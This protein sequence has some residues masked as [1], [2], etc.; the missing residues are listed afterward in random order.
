[1]SE[2]LVI[3]ATGKTGSRVVQRLEA[4]GARVRPVNR[5]SDP[6]FEWEA[7]ETWGQALKSVASAYVVYSPDLALPSARPVIA[8]FVKSAEKAGLK[9][10]VLLSQRNEIRAEACEDLIKKSSIEWTILKPSWFMQNFS[11]G[12]L[13][14]GVLT[15]T[16][17]APDSGAT[18]PWVDLDDVADVAVAALMDD[19]HVSQVYELTGP[20]SLGW[21]SAV[22]LIAEA[23]G[24]EISYKT[25]SPSQFAEFLRDS[26]YDSDTAEFVSN[27]VAEILDGKNSATADGVLRALGRNPKSFE[28]FVAGAAQSGFW[29]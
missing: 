9:R 27:L 14:D 13:R 18:E 22:S 25:I 3:G 16:V 7:P 11:E 5:S 20:T 6:S 4:L 21:D 26:G 12:E 29:S 17:M 1:M 28:E 15:G 24:R 8:D 23:T 2:V 10:L 19:K